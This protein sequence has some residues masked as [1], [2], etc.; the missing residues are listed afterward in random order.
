MVFKKEL[1]CV[2]SELIKED[3]FAPL[4]AAPPPPA[5]PGGFAPPPGDFVSPPDEP[6]PSLDLS[7]PDSPPAAD[8]TSLASF[9]NSSGFPKIDSSATTTTDGWSLLPSDCINAASLSLTLIVLISGS[10]FPLSPFE[11]LMN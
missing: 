4:A 11:P 5:P 2:I 6:W 9:F 7:P 8:P 3:P 10:S 1:S